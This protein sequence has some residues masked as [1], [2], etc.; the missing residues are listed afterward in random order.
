MYGNISERLMTVEEAMRL[1]ELSAGPRATFERPS[2][3][4]WQTVARAMA[5]AVTEEQVEAMMRKV[6]RQPE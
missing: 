1:S 2:I 3:W 6:A 5:Q 4:S